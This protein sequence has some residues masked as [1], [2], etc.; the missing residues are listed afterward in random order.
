MTFHLAEDVSDV[1]SIALESASSTDATDWV[2]E[3]AAA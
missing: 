3:H 1:L 2:G